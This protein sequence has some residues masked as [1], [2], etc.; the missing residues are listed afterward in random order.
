MSTMTIKTAALTL[1]LTA[2]TAS[3]SPDQNVVAGINAYKFL[4]VVLDATESGEDVRTTS[5]QL[6]IESVQPGNV[7]DDM[8][9]CQIYNGTNPT[10]TPLNTGTNVVNPVN[11]D[12]ADDDNTFTFDTG[13]IVSKGTVKILSL[14]CN[15]VGG[16]SATRLGWGLVDAANTAVSTGVT[17]GT[18][19][20]ETITGDLGRTIVINSAGTLALVLDPSSPALKLIQGGMIDQTLAVFRLNASYEDVRLNKLGLQL[21]STTVTASSSSADLVR[22]TLWDGSTFLGAVTFTSNFATATLTNFVIPKDG[23]KL[24]TVKADIAPIDVTLS[25]AVP[26]HLLIVNYDASWGDAPDDDTNE[27]AQGGKAVGIA[28]G[29]TI[30]TAGSDS[31]ANGGRLVKSVPTLTK[32]AHTNGKYVGTTNQSLYKFSIT[33]P[34]G[35]NGISLY[36]FTFNISTNT[37]LAPEPDPAILRV[38]N[39]RVFCYSDSAFSLGSC[40]NATG[41]L[42][43]FGLAV[44][45]GDNAAFDA[46]GDD[47]VTEADKDA[48]VA[49]LFN[50]AATSGA[51]AEGVRLSAGDVRY[52]ELKGDITDAT[53]SGT[54]SI[55][56]IL[57]GDPAWA[58]VTCG[59]GAAADYVDYIVIP[60]EGKDGTGSAA[61]TADADDVD[62]SDEDDFIWSSNSTNTTQS[63]DSAA[64][65]NGFLLPGLPTDSMAQETLLKQ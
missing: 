24:L 47:T 7:A 56:I 28:S 21:A 53:S 11:A 45:T 34:A 18:S 31:A 25:E 14:R 32:L 29:T 46:G 41:Q 17:S 8:T 23:Q 64:W 3:S 40:G 58:A 13:L 10:D 55:S 60:C 65:Q 52:F 5:M 1:S 35:G 37:P 36:K 54:P 50:P 42:N 26:G 49:I 63:I 43:Q 27:G 30:Y 4:D 44:A 22:A 38:E 19:V 12:V 2:S 16:S 6:R 15:I 62:T 57:L 51:T 39:L 33:A 48:D 20:T 59:D 61:F 9:N